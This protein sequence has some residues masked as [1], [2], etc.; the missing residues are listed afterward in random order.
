VDFVS[1][2]LAGG[3]LPPTEIHDDWTFQVSNMSGR[4]SMI[5]TLPQGWAVKRVTLDGRDITDEP[6]DFSAGDV[7]GIE[8]TLTSK[9]STITGSATDA[10]K[11]VTDYTVVVFSE[12]AEKW[13]YPSRFIGMSRSTPQGSFTILGLPADRY[14]AVALKAVPANQWQ[15]PEFLAKMRA[16]ATP[17]TLSDAENLTLT[18]KLVK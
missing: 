4:R 7:N 17:F 9:I 11:A 1:G 12:N 5:M 15:N 16:V 14:L 3:G 8:V 6:V 2:P 18:L 10:G 13:K